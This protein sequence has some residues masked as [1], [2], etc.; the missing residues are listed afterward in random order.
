M[1]DNWF[2]NPLSQCGPSQCYLSMSVDVRLKCASWCHNLLSQTAILSAVKPYKMVSHWCTPQSTVS[3]WPF[4]VV[5][6]MS[7]SVTLMCFSWCHHP[8]S[9]SPS[10]WQLD[11]SGG[12][13]LICL[14]W[15][16]NLYHNTPSPVVSSRSLLVDIT[17]HCNYQLSLVA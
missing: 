10:Q 1:C 5:K 15:C 4:P 7:A 8:L 9:Q 11:I 12:L 6:Y 13:T 14:S 3:I 17:L 2:H 16:H